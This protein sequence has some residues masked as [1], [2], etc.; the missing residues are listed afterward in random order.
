[1]LKSVN[2][3]AASIED[4]LVRRLVAKI[5]LNQAEIMDYEKFL[6]DDADIIIVAYGGTA[7]SAMRAVKLARAEG[8]KAGMLRL[9]TLWPFPGPVVQELSQRGASFLVPEMNLGQL[10]LEVERIAASRTKVR[11]LS[12]VDA[13]YSPRTKFLLALKEGF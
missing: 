3:P 4:Q 11:H 12:R 7:R 6:T 8:I 13:N 2:P 5:D 1:M 10:V 9:K